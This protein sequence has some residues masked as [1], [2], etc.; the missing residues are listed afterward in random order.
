MSNLIGEAKNAA[1]AA[2]KVLHDEKRR[3]V[4]STAK[5]IVSAHLPHKRLPVEQFA[6]TLEEFD[7]MLGKFQST[8]CRWE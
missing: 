4:N 6:A 5:I 7:T 1:S 2:V 8:K 3:N